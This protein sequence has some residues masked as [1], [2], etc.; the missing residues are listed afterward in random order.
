MN[1]KGCNMLAV[2]TFGAVF[3]AGAFD[4]LDTATS[5]V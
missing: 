1:H 5:G 4:P 3:S 2:L